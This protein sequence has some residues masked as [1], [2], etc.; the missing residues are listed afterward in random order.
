MGA[1]L[2]P[3]P[4]GDRRRIAVV[5]LTAADVAPTDADIAV[6]GKEVRERSAVERRVDGMG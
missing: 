4:I 2:A 3:A 1:E 5:D 6:A